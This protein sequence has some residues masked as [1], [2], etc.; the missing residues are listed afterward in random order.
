VIYPVDKEPLSKWFGLKR[1]NYVLD[2]RANEEDAL[3]YARRTSVDINKQITDL[4]ISLGANLAPKKLYWG[5][6]GG[7][8]THTI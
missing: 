2:P 6:S 1:S 8:K 3:F 5:T 4:E 7:G